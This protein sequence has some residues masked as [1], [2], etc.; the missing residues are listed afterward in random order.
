MLTA[1]DF[2][3][4]SYVFFSGVH[5][6]KKALPGARNY[7]T[8]V[9]CILVSTARRGS[10]NTR[11]SALPSFSSAF[12][13]ASYT[14]K[15]PIWHLDSLLL[16]FPLTVKCLSVASA[17]KLHQ[18]R[19]RCFAVI[20][21]RL[22]GCVLCFFHCIQRG[23]RCAGYV[24]SF[25]VLYSTPVRHPGGRLIYKLVCSARMH[26]LYVLFSFCFVPQTALETILVNLEKS[27]NVWW[28]EIP[29]QN[30]PGKKQTNK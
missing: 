10:V 29:R 8:F 19:D 22:S 21:A 28:W 23:A 3:F 17:G 24:P 5:V 14:S 4:F 15:W 9:W 26:C 7:Y 18:V 2:F 16:C 11:R 13:V 1:L 27:E 12:F 20:C 30:A 25:E 6:F